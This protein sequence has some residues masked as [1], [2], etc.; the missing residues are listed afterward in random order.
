MFDMSGFKDAVSDALDAC[1]TE[2]SEDYWTVDDCG[3]LASSIVWH[4][5]LNALNALENG[6]GDEDQLSHDLAV[7]RSLRPVADSEGNEW[8]E[9]VPW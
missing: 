9:C 3:R 2:A 6:T 4:L 8:P 1:D 5:Y 7:A